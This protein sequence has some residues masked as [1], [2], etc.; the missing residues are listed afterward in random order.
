MKIDVFWGSL[1][2]NKE[3]FRSIKPQPETLKRLP[4]SHGKNILDQ[5][6]RA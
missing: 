5:A 2:Y 4:S 3:L 6:G 1:F